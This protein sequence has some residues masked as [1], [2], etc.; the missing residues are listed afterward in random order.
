MFNTN[1][2][3]TGSLSVTDCLYYPGFTPDE[4]VMKMPDY[5]PELKQCVPYE[6]GCF[7]DQMVDN[8]C[9]TCPVDHYR[10][11]QNVHPIACP[12][13]R[14]SLAQSNSIHDCTYTAGNF[15]QYS[16]GPPPSLVCVSCHTGTYSSQPNASA[17]TDCPSNTY[18][19]VRGED[20][21]TDCYKYPQH[22]ASLPGST[23][24]TD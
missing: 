9:L 17:C 16:H 11:D 7:K 3:D 8:S 10:P 24:Q 5:S 4:T 18:Y 20:N 14:V 23:N 6:A 13:D 19:N 22:A 1:T 15:H 12:K 2:T 21:V